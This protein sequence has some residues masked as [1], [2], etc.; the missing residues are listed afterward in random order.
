[1]SKPSVDNIRLVVTMKKSLRDR[2]SKKAEEE[3]R[4]MSNYINII[5]E[6]YLNQLEQQN[7]K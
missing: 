3:R 7:Q 2:L 1:M 6:D 5:V 4:S